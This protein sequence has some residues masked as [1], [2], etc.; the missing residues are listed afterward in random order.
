MGEIRD[1]IQ[2]FADFKAEFAEAGIY[3]T[4]RSI[5]ASAMEGTANFPMLIEDSTPI[6]DC[7]T[8]ARAAE[9]KFASFLL[10]YYNSIDKTGP[11]LQNHRTR[12][13][14]ENQIRSGFV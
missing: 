13:V 3:S 11:V 2:T 14:N 6:E 4:K 12:L 10:R 8:I 5:S 7:I 9:K 1:A